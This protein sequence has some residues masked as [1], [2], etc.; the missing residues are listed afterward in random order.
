MLKYIAIIIYWC[1]K[2]KKGTVALLSLG[3]LGVVLLLNIVFKIKMLSLLGLMILKLIVKVML[4]KILLPLV[5]KKSRWSKVKFS[6]VKL[7][8]NKVKKLLR[9]NA[10]GAV[11]IIRCKYLLKKVLKRLYNR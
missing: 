10:G 6:I 9:G 3:F 11:K 2:N 8:L 1:Y 7:G 5:L 4:L